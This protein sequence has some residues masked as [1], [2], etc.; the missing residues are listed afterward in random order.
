MPAIPPP[1][2]G[3]WRGGG[4]SACEIGAPVAVGSSCFAA[5]DGPRPFADRLESG[6]GG[7]FGGVC[8]TGPPPCSVL[9][10]AAG[11]PPPQMAHRKRGRGSVRFVG[12]SGH[13]H[14]V[15]LGWVMVRHSQQRVLR[16]VRGGAWRARRQV[17]PPRSVLGGTGGPTSRR[18]AFERGG[19]S[20]RRVVAR[21][22]PYPSTSRPRF[23]HER[24]AR[25]ATRVPTLF[26]HPLPT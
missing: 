7:S 4:W 25:I 14:S 22:A 24:P 19:V 11:P 18:E 3:V 6:V 13:S 9:Q 16:G 8:G 12:R 26:R 17:G 15:L 20:G 5:A 1:T 2:Q 10:V 21:H 23:R